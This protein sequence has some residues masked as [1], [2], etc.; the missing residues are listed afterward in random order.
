MLVEIGSVLFWV[1]EDMHSLAYLRDLCLQ[2][3]ERWLLWVA[4]TFE[5]SRAV[6]RRLE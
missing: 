3:R 2:A 4:L 1:E 6:R 5:L